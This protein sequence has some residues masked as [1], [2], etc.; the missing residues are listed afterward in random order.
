VT[1]SQFKSYCHD[2]QRVLSL[3]ANLGLSNINIK[4]QVKLLGAWCHCHRVPQTAVCWF[5]CKRSVYPVRAYTYTIFVPQI[6]C[7]SR[8]QQG[9]FILCYCKG[10]LGFRLKFYIWDLS[11]WAQLNNE[12]SNTT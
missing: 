11:R 9:E 3:R 10:F 4:H 6:V 12:T 5:Y 1:P 2:H 7:E 8:S